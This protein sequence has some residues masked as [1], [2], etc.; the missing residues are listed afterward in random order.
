M[1]FFLSRMPIWGLQFIW[2]LAGKT[3]LKAD[4]R[5]QSDAEREAR[6]PACGASQDHLPVPMEMVMEGAQLLCL[7]V[8]LGLL[9][10]D[11]KNPPHG[12]S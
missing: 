7:N 6:L 5:A 12:L 10:P 3:L 4:G 9:A 8:L 11:P 2:H 1:A